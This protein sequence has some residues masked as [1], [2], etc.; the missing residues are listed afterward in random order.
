MYP[1]QLVHRGGPPSSSSPNAGGSNAEPPDVKFETT[2][3]GASSYRRG[4]KGCINSPNGKAVVSSSWE[5]DGMTGKVARRCR[6]SE[7]PAVSQLHRCDK[8]VQTTYLGRHLANRC[9]QAE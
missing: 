8:L 1:R 4:A 9:L 6:G 5:L 7:L 2:G 3:T